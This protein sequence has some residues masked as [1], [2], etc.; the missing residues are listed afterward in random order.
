MNP[1]PDITDFFGTKKSIIFD[2]DGTLVDVLQVFIEIFNTLALLFVFAK[3]TRI[4]Y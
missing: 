2:F 3:F 4:L 1:S